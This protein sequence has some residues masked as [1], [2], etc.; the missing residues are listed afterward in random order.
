MDEVELQEEFIEFF[1]KPETNFES[2]LSSDTSLIEKKEWNKVAI[3][4]W[5][6]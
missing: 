6:P 4:T 2:K 3:V 1:Y 5:L